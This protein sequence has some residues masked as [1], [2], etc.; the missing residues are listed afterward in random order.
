MD[1]KDAYFQIPVHW[2]LRKLLHFTSEG[3]VYQFKVLCFGLST[4]SQVFTRVFAAV[5]AWAHSRGIRLLWYL[6]D[7]LVLASSE[8][9]ARHHFPEL[10]SLCHSLEIVINDEK[11][12]LMPLQSATYLGM[13][14]DT[15]AAK[16]FPTLARVEKFLSVAEQFLTVTTPPARL[17]QVLLWHLSSLEKLVPH[18]HLRMRSLQWHLKTHWSPESDPPDLPVPRSREVEEDLSWWMVRD[19]PFGTPAPDRHL[20]SDASLSRWGAHLLDRSVSGVWSVQESSQHINL[21]EMKALFLALQSFQEMVTGHHV[22][23]M[24][25]NSTVV[26]YINRQDRT[27]SDSLCS[28]TRQLLQWAESFDVQLEARYLPGQSNV[29]ADLLSRRE[30]VIGSE[31]SLHH[32]VARALLCVWGSPSLDLFV[33]HLK[34]KLPR[35]GSPGRL[36]GCVPTSVGRARRV[37]FSSLSPGREGCGSSQR[38]PKSLHDSG[39]PS[40]AGEGVVCGPPSVDPTTSGTTSVGPAASAAP[41]QPLPPGRPRLEP[42]CVAT[43][44]R[45]PQK[46]GFLRG[47]AL[48]MSS[49][50][51]ESTARLYQ[52]KWLSSVVGVVEGALF[53]S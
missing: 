11:S 27:V 52:A 3:T 34:A 32:Q 1:L 12:D 37:R 13:T 7:W 15:V 49:C 35:S 25:D 53:Q 10:L 8:A 5:S 22:T 40:L 50:V 24:C 6:D 39:R 42:S 33:T 20:Y 9:V 38:D 48:E 4:A 28:L 2:S 29:L 43:L 41:L 51:R 45:L 21:L 47:A 30:Q 44:K 26:A 23:A 17:W 36:R 18:R 14:I 19:V 46:S 31:W 16:V